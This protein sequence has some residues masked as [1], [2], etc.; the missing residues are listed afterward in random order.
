M[1]GADPSYEYID[2]TADLG[3]RGRG[4]TLG[5]AFASAATGLFR[6][7]IDAEDVRGTREIPLEMEA[8]EADDLLL[9]WLR[10]WLYRQQV[11]LL[12][13]EGFE[14]EVTPGDG[15]EP[16]RI[17]SVAHAEDYDRDRH[18]HVH[19]VKA[20]TYHAIEVQLDPPMVE[21]IVDI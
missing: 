9:D 18:G 10:E 13:F 5:E 19:E 14:A 17:E 15:D 6:Y 7:V 12:A 1:V 2:H 4:E 11:D 3:I 20:I 21:V 16:W 8:P